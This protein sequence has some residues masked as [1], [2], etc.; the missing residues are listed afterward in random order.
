MS[1]PSLRT[2]TAPAPPAPEEDLATPSIPVEPAQT[3]S[4]PRLAAWGTALTV[5]GLALTIFA[6]STTALHLGGKA[7]LLVI[8]LGVLYA[9]ASRL[10]WAVRGQRVD[11]LVWL[12]ATWLILICVGAAL[13]P[14]LPLGEHVDVSAS[15]LEPTYS[16]PELLSAHPLGT[17]N[18]GLDLFARS[19]YGARTS[20]TIALLAVAVG[21]LVGGAIGVIA[22]YFRS[23]VDSVVGI[24]TNAL[25]AVPPLILLIAL[26]TFLKPSIRN[27][28]LALALLTIPSMIRLARANTIAFA[29]REFVSAARLIGA[30][31]LRIMVRELVPN[32]LPPVMSMAVVL[33]SVMIVAEAS[34]SFLGLG[35]QQPEPTWGNMIS[36]GEGGVMEQHPQI[37][38]VPGAFLFLTVFAF[39]LLGERAQQRWDPRSAKL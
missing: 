29:Q 36:E 13:A 20:L 4:R 21:T 2:T 26:A 31:R 19:V 16:R 8:G 1:L 18:F 34:L 39:N 28:A 9:G 27:M 32:V 38:L 3:A 23:G 17:N 5:V 6:W 15:L 11:L 37:V 10:A 7:P 24:F 30:S 22:G 35:I 33:I 25:L 14:W 12:C